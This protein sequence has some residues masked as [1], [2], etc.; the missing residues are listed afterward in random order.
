MPGVTTGTCGRTQ[1]GRPVVLEGL[2]GK[3]GEGSVFGVVG[4]PGLAVKVYAASSADR[5]AKLRAMIAT[6]QTTLD[7]FCTWPQA[8][9]TFPGGE[10]GFS[11]PKL[12]GTWH[13]IDRLGSP[14][15]RKQH[16]PAATWRF[17]VHTATNLARAFGAVH[18][19]GHVVGDV[20]ENNIRVKPSGLVR[21]IDCD[22]FQV[23]HGGRT[24]R[25]TVGVPTHT[26]PEL[27]KVNLKDVDRTMDHDRF[28]LAVAIFQLL[29][30]GRHPFAGT[31]LQAG[32]VSIE[33]AIATGRFAYLPA[34]P[35]DGLR[36]PPHTPALSIAPE[37]T[38]TLFRRAFVPSIGGAPRP[39]ADEWISNLDAL[40]ADLRRCRVEQ[41]HEY[42]GHES[43]CPWCAIEAGTKSP[44]FSLFGQT[45]T[46]S[47]IGIFSKTDWNE[48]EKKLTQL[49]LPVSGPPPATAPIH[50]TQA[51]PHAQ[52]LMKK[53]REEYERAVR[54]RHAAEIQHVE[55]TK[56]H[57]EVVT[58][59]T[60]RNTQAIQAHAV[61]CERAKSEHALTTAKLAEEYEASKQQLR[62]IRSFIWPATKV[63]LPVAGAVWFI[64]WLQG[65]RHAAPLLVHV[66]GLAAFGAVATAAALA[67]LYHKGT[68]PPKPAPP[69]LKLPPPPSLETV[70]PPPLPPVMR[71]PPPIS[72]SD[73]AFVELHRR[74]VDD[75]NTFNQAKV[76]HTM[77]LTTVG[78]LA[79]HP[80]FGPVHRQAQAL[81][82]QAKQ[83]LQRRQYRI[84]QLNGTARQHALVQHLATHRLEEGMVEGI[85]PSR[86]ATLRSYSIYTAADIDPI[87]ISR[88]PG[89]GPVL[90]GNLSFWRSML[91]VSWTAPNHLA[92][93]A[94]DI[95]G[96]DA[97]I[98]QERGSLAQNALPLIADMERIRAEVVDELTRSA[99][100]VNELAMRAGQSEADLRYLKATFP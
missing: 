38:A 10:L 75:T 24:Y 60:L 77:R 80:K 33:D 3:G 53:R 96:I 59:I 95:A 84:D 67:Y 98:A 4:D 46:A 32:D 64:F 71:V 23:S 12:D 100:L 29:F 56:Q 85:G 18:A 14:R 83:A 55:A 93:S 74:V 88:I 39:S 94:A 22:G 28:G 82:G 92:P 49:L 69:A 68:S 97:S 37:E 36:R 81:L 72:S 20:N 90:R 16:F 61:D 50:A 51:S 9:I 44:G 73:A 76:R 11:M 62:P 41:R 99:N 47:T 19:A 43:S 5:D 13:S 27:Q 58:Q 34:Q 7:T 70:P 65:G 1:D 6:R 87:K 8:V 91:E 52:D 42:A 2:L 57:S 40:L 26:P 30:L 86:I 31:P 35:P 15:D 17:L 89:F 78:A 25:C 45:A 63:G 21:L 66:G 48:I 54:E 79:A